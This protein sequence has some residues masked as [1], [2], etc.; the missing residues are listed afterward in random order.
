MRWFTRLFTKEKPKEQPH[1]TL[2][3]QELD[4]WFRAKVSAKLQSVKDD[5][6]RILAE[7]HQGIQA[8]KEKLNKLETAH[9]QNPNIPMRAK[10][11]MEGNREAYIRAISRVLPSVDANELEP[12]EIPAFTQQAKQRFEQLARITHKPY[13]ILQEFLA[14]EAVAV[15]RSLKAILAIVERLEAHYKAAG[16]AEIQAM[17]QAIS[18]I[19]N[20]IVQKQT[21]AKSKAQLEQEIAALNTAVSALAAEKQALMISKRYRQYTLLKQEKAE[22]QQQLKELEQSFLD[23]FQAVEPALKRFAKRS[24]YEE[25]ITR[26]LSHPIAAL[27]NDDGLEII[28]VLEALAQ[29]IT[30]NAVQ[31]NDR[32]EKK[33]LEKI[34]FLNQAFLDD[35]R[36]KHQAATQAMSGIASRLEM[37]KVEETLAV[38]NQKLTD[39]QYRLENKGL[40][41]AHSRKELEKIDIE[42][43]SEDL[44]ARLSSFLNEQVSLAL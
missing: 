16:L 42:R 7:L 29:N 35:F 23:H 41:L 27:M 6:N 39:E 4:A 10:Q 13:T 31:L 2:Q 36:K 12:L 34:Q 22:A 1:H 43:F 5:T 21:L 30:S 18:A 9:L 20:K 24:T 28:P 8:A 25:R 44:A 37:T 14:N 19:S 26:Y 11:F 3:L 15:A 38:H 33:T 40:Q 32:K 17:E